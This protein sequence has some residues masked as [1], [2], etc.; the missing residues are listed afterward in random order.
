MDIYAFPSV[1]FV[2]Y[3]YKNRSTKNKQR[4]AMVA[5]P[6]LLEMAIRTAMLL[7]GGPQLL[8]VPAPH[9]VLNCCPGL[10][11]QSASL[12]TTAVH[13]GRTEPRALP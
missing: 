7:A 6:C 3:D 8:R 11:P 4:A 10:R 12:C 13:R 1:L 5:T 2:V 9:P